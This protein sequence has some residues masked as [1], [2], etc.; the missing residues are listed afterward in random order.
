MTQM[1]LSELQKLVQEVMEVLRR[2]EANSDKFEKRLDSLEAGFG[3]RLNS[4]ESNIDTS[5]DS[6]AEQVGS[7]EESVGLFHKTKEND[8]RDAVAF[9]LPIFFFCLAVIFVIFIF[10]RFL[11]YLFL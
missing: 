6:S 7:P 8:L 4:A 10:V 2:I 1:E 9:F 5:F 11:C 3:T